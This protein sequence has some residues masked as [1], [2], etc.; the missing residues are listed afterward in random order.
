MHVLKS[1]FKYLIIK[2]MWL[3]DK[4]S[5]TQKI[6]YKIYQFLLGLIYSSMLLFIIIFLFKK[7]KSKNN[8]D[9]YFQ[10]LFTLPIQLLVFLKF[11]FTVF[12]RNSILQLANYFIKDEFKPRDE[13]EKKQEEKY[14]FY[15]K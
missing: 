15:I 4:V 12:K 9:D 1:V 5:N 11:I 13:Y 8:L 2:G 14:E 10:Q 6:F 7:I 3:P